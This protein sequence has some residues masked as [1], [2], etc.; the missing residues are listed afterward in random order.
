M[1]TKLVEDTQDAVAD[2]MARGLAFWRIDSKLHAAPNSLS[3]AVRAL[4]VGLGIGLALQFVVL[5]VRL[6]KLAENTLL[7]GVV[8]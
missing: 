6:P 4:G 2:W 3:N 7:G 5:F 1:R 8:P